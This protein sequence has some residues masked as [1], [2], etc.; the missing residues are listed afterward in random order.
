M[1]IHFLW[2]TEESGTVWHCL[3]QESPASL[4]LPKAGPIL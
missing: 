2:R 3:D 1:I 4:D